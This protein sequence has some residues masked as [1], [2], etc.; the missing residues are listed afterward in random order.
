MKGL[1]GR[2]GLDPEEGMFF[3]DCS[4]IHMFMM[5]FAI[6]V[7]YVDAAMTVTKI[8]SDLKPWR[9]SGCLGAR[10]V[11]ELAAGRAKEKDVRVGDKLTF[12]D[13]RR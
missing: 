10:G 4:S 6:D 3:P 12:E 1:L 9:L 8:V 13:A 11:V 2:R 7:I 5:L